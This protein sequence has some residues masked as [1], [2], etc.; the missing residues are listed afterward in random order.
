MCLVRGMSPI[1]N[2]LIGNRI[3][4]C[5][6]PPLQKLVKR[7]MKFASLDSCMS[8]L[9]KCAYRFIDGIDNL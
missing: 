8:F 2:I 4:F 1:G 7:K 3:S 9:T 6:I 5:A